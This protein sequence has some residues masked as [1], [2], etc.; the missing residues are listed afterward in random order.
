MLVLRENIMMSFVIMIK[1][2][3]YAAPIKYI[4]LLV[5]SFIITNIFMLFCMGAEITL[6]G[7]FLRVAFLILGFLCLFSKLNTKDII[8]RS[9]ILRE[10]HKLL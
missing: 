6:L 10:I 5:I 9:L 3:M 7:W 8:S 1:E 2:E 4:S